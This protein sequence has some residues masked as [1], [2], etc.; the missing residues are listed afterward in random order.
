MTRALLIAALII[1]TFTPAALASEGVSVNTV[2]AT[3]DY[4]VVVDQPTLFEAE[5][6]LC[7][8]T[9]EYWCAPPP[10][11]VFTDSVLWLYDASGV[12]LAVNDDDPRRA[13]QSYNSYIGAELQPGIYRLRAGR[14]ICYDGS[15]IHPE[16]PFAEG[17]QYDLLTN[18]PLVLDPTPPVASP[19]PV[20]SELPSPSVEPSA[21][22]PSPTP[23]PSP[24]SPSPSP[25]P[26]PT[27]TPEPSPTPTPTPEPTVTPE[28]PT[29]TPTI[30]PT[31]MPT[32]TPTVQVS[33]EPTPTPSPSMPMVSPTTDPS[34][35]PS[36]LVSPEP[37]PEP[38]ATDPV[39]V[40]GE[41][42]AAVGEALADVADTVSAA[43]GEAAAAV[44][45]LGT[46]QTPATREKV[47][48]IA[49]PAIVVQLV[50][51]A[52]SAAAAAANLINKRG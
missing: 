19:P 48:T 16:A 43:V 22:L 49:V 44:S 52:S 2:T 21:E 13:G 23:E 7:P 38:P 25:T 3:T 17:G 39:G 42:I 24:E 50:Q 30:A 41:A 26:E 35:T 29:P 6:D 46:D 40:A 32:P 36:P 45:R 15:C 8:D 11:G 34:P 18:L 5:T 27:A 28:P 51:A 33:I 12:L 10:A 47:R 1:A 14:F 20:P 4:F 9:N 37:T 31:P